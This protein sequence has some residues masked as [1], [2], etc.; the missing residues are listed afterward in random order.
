MFLLFLLQKLTLY[1]KVDFQ[2]T[3]ERDS[4]IKTSVTKIT[5]EKK[6]VVVTL[7]CTKKV[8]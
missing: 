2:K 6:S 8:I 4:W 1:N 3:T 7:F 5:L